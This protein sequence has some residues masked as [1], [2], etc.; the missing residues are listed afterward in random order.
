MLCHF[1]MAIV[2]VARLVIF[3]GLL[4][5]MMSSKKKD[6]GTLDCDSGKILQN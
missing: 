6:Q 5:F 2:V 1:F 3:V 4:N